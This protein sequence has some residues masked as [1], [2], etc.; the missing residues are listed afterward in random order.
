VT[1]AKERLWIVCAGRRML[2]GNDSSN[3]PSR[4]IKEISDEYLDKEILRRE[5]RKTSIMDNINSDADYNIGD[6]IN[7]TEF[8]EGIIVSV[9]KSI[10]TIAFPHPYGIKKIM[11]GHKSI[12]KV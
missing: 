8:G 2:F 9:D 1:R 11:K 4:F 6:K 5:N 7:H 10:L 12:V 3:P